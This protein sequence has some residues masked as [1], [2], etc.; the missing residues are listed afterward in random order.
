MS[1]SDFRY[2]HVNSVRES[3]IQHKGNPVLVAQMLRE[4]YSLKNND[5]GEV[6]FV[7]IFDPLPEKGNYTVEDKK[8]LEPYVMVPGFVKW[9]FRKSSEAKKV[10]ELISPVG[11]KNRPE[12]EEKIRDYCYNGQIMYWEP[13]DFF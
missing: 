7:G 5:T 1:E 4:K 9:P 8:I 11:S 10:T 13:E 12:L 6:T 2:I 3:I